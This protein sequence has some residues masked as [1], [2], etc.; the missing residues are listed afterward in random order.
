V[1]KGKKSR[2][3]R[4]KVKRKE[5]GGRGGK[6]REEKSGLGEKKQVLPRTQKGEQS[7]GE[8]EVRVLAYEKAG[9]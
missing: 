2:G 8:E 6:K 9:E 7:S 1:L 4:G 5:K 3:G